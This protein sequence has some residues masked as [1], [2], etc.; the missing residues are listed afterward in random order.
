MAVYPIAR[1]AHDEAIMV[2]KKEGDSSDIVT[3]QWLTNY[4]GQNVIE[5]SPIE[6]PSITEVDNGLLISTKAL[7]YKEQFN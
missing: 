4:K 6:T 3:E 7:N 2:I 5:V 1:G